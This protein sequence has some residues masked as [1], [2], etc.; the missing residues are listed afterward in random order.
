VSDFRPRVLAGA[1]LACWTFEP[2]M[3]FFPSTRSWTGLPTDLARGGVLTAA[4]VLFLEW[5]LVPLSQVRLKRI[6]VNHYGALFVF[7]GLVAVCAADAARYGG[8]PVMA[9]TGVVVG[10]IWVM[11]VA[12]L[13]YA[14]RSERFPLLRSGLF[15]ALSAVIFVV[16]D[17]AV[18]VL[19]LAALV[20]LRG[21]PDAQVVLCAGGLVLAVL[22]LPV[23]VRRVRGYWPM[24]PWAAPRV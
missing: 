19:S 17:L 20:F 22:G 12:S 15:L 18:G 10:V 13:V 11:E 24:L 7:P 16:F 23:D 9:G 4:L 21:Q 14:W 1:A 8:G 2:I 3:M 6:W 5:L